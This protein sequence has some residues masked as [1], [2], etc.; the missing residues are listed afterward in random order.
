MQLKYAGPRPLISHSGIAFDRKKEDKYL[1]IEYVIHL[2]NAL[3]HDYLE[4]SA[5]TYNPS[6]RSRDDA[7]L[8]STL[9]QY[10]PEAQTHALQRAEKMRDEL[11]REI[12]DAQTNRLLSEEERLPLL[13]NLKMMQTYRLQR[14]YNKS[15]YYSAVR[16]LLHV[17][18]AKRIRYITMPF[19]PAFLHVAHTLEGVARQQR[20][21]VN[22]A[23]KV[24]YE[25]GILRA[26]LDFTAR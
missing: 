2:L 11:R 1:Y 13:N 18:I 4:N 14:T 24:V 9:Q 22:A 8:L 25:N 15:L 23:L 3:D 26:R 17:I 19:A 6:L 10:D 12:D 5:Y 7:A 21:A 20:F 16:A